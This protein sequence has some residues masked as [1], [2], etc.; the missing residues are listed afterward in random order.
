MAIIDCTTTGSA[1]TSSNTNWSGGNSPAVI[2]AGG[3]EPRVLVAAGHTLTVDDDAIFGGPSFTASDAVATSKCLDVAP[4]AFLTFASG[5]ILRTR[6]NTLVQNTAFTA[7]EGTPAI[8]VSAGTWRFD[9]TQHASPSAQNYYIQ[10][11]TNNGCF[12][13]V[14]VR[15]GGVME[16]VVGGAQGRVTGGFFELLDAVLRRL[17]TAALPCFAAYA[18]YD[19]GAANLYLRVNNTSFDGC[20]ELNLGNTLFGGSVLDVTYNRFRGGLASRDV[21]VNSVAATNPAIHLRN[22]TDNG[23]EVGLYGILT[24]LVIDRNRARRIGSQITTWGARSFNGNLRAL[25]GKNTCPENETFGYVLEERTSSNGSFGSASTAAPVLSEDTI[26]ESAGD[27]NSDGEIFGLG[28]GNKKLTARRC[29][30]V[31]NRDGVANRW[32]EFNPGTRATTADT[33]TYERCSGHS[34]RFVFGYDH[35]ST[36]A[37]DPVQA[38]DCLIV[39]ASGN[40]AS[41]APTDLTY[42]HSVTGVI[43]GRSISALIDNWSRPM[44]RR[45]ATLG[46]YVGNLGRGYDHLESSG[47][48]AASGQPGDADLTDR[49]PWPGRTANSAQYLGALPGARRFTSYGRSKGLSGT[50][51]EVF[52][53]L[54]TAFVSLD[55]P[56][57][58]GYVA[59]V[60]IAGLRA[61]VQADWAPTDLF[62][63]TAGWSGGQIGAVANAAAAPLQSP[64]LLLL[65]PH[66]ARSRRGR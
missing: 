44:F 48:L 10:V 27:G 14:R 62:F 29:I 24:D 22:I 47:E 66:W 50:E 19:A 26:Y 46:L 1:S 51:D 23:M 20:G 33:P 61:W 21:Y 64:N 35:G 34:S 36:G 28:A 13:R 52:A 54:W 25:S 32:A 5:G 30:F 59:G 4:G 16:S 53:A 37:A 6:G 56:S 12:R 7:Y 38:D 17:G 42:R 63:A 40:S 57:A 31:G 18:P 15:N 2:R 41:S 3:D 39:G 58:P 49:S 11:G 9:A 8:D 45:I 65:F 60:S 43:S 55:D